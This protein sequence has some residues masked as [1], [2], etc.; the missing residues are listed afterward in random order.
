MFRPT[1]KSES[2]L[3]CLIET[4]GYMAFPIV[5]IP[6][7]SSDLQGHSPIA[8]LFKWNSSKS[9]AA[10]GKIST[11]SVARPFCDSWASCEL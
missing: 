8:S 9:C 2:A 11:D 7:T 6:M 5:A 10:V 3:T 1:H 4:E